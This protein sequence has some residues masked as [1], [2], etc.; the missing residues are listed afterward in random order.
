MRGG[1][2][3]LRGRRL[4][5]VSVRGQEDIISRSFTFG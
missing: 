3:G 5:D 2:M 4:V 1:R